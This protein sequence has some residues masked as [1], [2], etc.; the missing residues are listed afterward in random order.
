MVFIT[1][2]L[3]CLLCRILCVL[4]HRQRERGMYCWGAFSRWL[5]DESM[6]VLGG[7][8]FGCP[9]YFL[10]TAKALNINPPH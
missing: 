5:V 2:R 8:N 1:W 4:L 10:K 9:A 3:E 7:C 6:Q